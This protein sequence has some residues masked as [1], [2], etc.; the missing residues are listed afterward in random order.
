MVVLQDRVGTLL[1]FIESW[2]YLRTLFV[3]TTVAVARRL[4]PYS[5]IYFSHIG[6]TVL[7]NQSSVSIESPSNMNRVSLH[8]MWLMWANLRST[9]AYCQPREQNQIAFI[10]ARGPDWWLYLHCRFVCF[11]LTYIS[12]VRIISTSQSP[13]KQI[14]C[15]VPTNSSWMASKSNCLWI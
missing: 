14:T 8:Q 3:N 12:D 1:L 15:L 2:I 11:V 10:Q 13:S 9:S 6:V 7:I 4:S 5:C